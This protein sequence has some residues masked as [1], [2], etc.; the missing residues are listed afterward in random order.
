MVGE[1]GSGPVTSGCRDQ[2]PQCSPAQ[3][4]WVRVP[5]D[6]CKHEINWLWSFRL[7][8][9]RLVVC[10]V[11]STACCESGLKRRPGTG[12]QWEPLPAA[13]PFVPSE[14]RGSAP[15]AHESQL[16]CGSVRRKILDPFQCL[17]FG[18]CIF[19]FCFCD[20][21]NISLKILFFIWNIFV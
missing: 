19:L 18:W 5:G 17:T 13:K 7:C 1:R 15:S 2:A 8:P 3:D 11:V 16:V 4:A 10:C 6:A 12:S 20:C 21:C 14:P 9:F